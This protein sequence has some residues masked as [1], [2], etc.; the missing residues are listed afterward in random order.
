MALRTLDAAPEY[1]F[2][3]LV[4]GRRVAGQEIAAMLS[5]TIV[6]MASDAKRKRSSL[7]KDLQVRVFRRDGWLCR[8]CGSPVV[9]A[10]AM[11][12]TERWIGDQGCSSPL[13]YHDRDGVVIE[14]RSWIT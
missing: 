12:L 2:I 4:A 1:V 3:R 9:F 6:S 8:W 11:R 10:P 14:P 7:P 13:A 5:A